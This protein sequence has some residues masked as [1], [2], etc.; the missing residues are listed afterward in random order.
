MINPRKERKSIE[1]FDDDKTHIP[2]HYDIERTNG[3]IKKIVDFF[4]AAET[5]SSVILDGIAVNSKLYDSI[6]MHLF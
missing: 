2:I 5:L 6:V 4:D 1:I 3:S